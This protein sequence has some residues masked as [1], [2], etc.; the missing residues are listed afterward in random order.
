V[1]VSYLSRLHQQQQQ[2][3]SSG[4]SQRTP[5]R[6]YQQAA[7][8]AYL[9]CLMLGL[10]LCG[11]LACREGAPSLLQPSM[12]HSPATAAVTSVHCQGTGQHRTQYACTQPF[13]QQAPQSV[14]LVCTLFHRKTAIT[15]RIL[16][17]VHELCLKQIHVTKRDL[18]YTDVKLFEVRCLTSNGVCWPAYQPVCVLPNQGSPC[19]LLGA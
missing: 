3:Y 15:T 13:L 17:L 12:L 1:Q 8:G 6:S 14:I 2:N 16:S 19:C 7:A 4:S 11:M 9:P 18:F 5:Q 10:L